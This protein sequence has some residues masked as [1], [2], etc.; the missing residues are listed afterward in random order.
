MMI[1]DLTMTMGGR[2]MLPE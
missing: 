1:A 2:N